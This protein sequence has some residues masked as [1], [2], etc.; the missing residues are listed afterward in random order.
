VS[1]LQEDDNNNNKTCYMEFDVVTVIWGYSLGVSSPGD[2]ADGAARN[3][4]MVTK[5]AFAFHKLAILTLLKGTVLMTG[6]G[7]HDHSV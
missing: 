5:R 7:S 3:K 2:L 4:T 6:L 1:S